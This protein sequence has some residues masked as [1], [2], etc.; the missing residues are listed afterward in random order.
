MVAEPSR[1]RRRAARAIAGLLALLLALSGCGPGE[2]P[3]QTSPPAPTETPTER[4]PT[5]SPTEMPATPTA[6]A[7]GPAPV[8]YDD[9]GSPDGTVALMYLLSHPGVDLLA[10]SISYGEAHP[11]IYIQHMGRKLDDLGI[12]DI[13]LGAG[14]DG[15]LSG[16]SSFPEEVRQ[17]SD[18]F[19]GFPIPNAGNTYPAQDAAELMVSVIKQSPEPVTVFLSGPGTDLALALRLDPGIREDIAAVW[20]MGGAVYVPG[21]ITDFYAE[22]DNLVAEWNVFADPLATSEVLGAG[23][24]IY[25]VPLDATNQVVITEQDTSQWREGGDAAGFAAYF[26]DTLMNGFGADS[27]MIWD[28]MT[29]AIMLKP[30]L[31][32]FQPL[33]LQVVTKEGDTLGQTAIVPGGE[34]NVNVCLEP[35]ADM[36]RQT[37]SEVFAGSE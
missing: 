13:P 36:I 25:M 29:A 28:L 8:L 3:A 21:N 16:T 9:D 1:I 37:L 23:L 31:C 17:L 10:V 33:A 35:D 24:D 34:P 4:E 18:D 12:T 15:P 26:Y 14:Q 7:S 2:Q 27:M 22:T 19:W 5:A 6:S 20:M 30:E 11:A 32:G